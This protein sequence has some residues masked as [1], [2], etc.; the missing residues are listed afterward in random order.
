MR[1]YLLL[2]MGIYLRIIPRMRRKPGTLL[3]IEIAIC[4]SAAELRAAGIEEFYGYQL[5]KH[6]GTRGNTRLLTA[7]GTLYRALD[8]LS[9][10]GLVTSRWESPDIPARENRPG[11]RLYML[12]GAAD[13]VVEAAAR[14]RRQRVSSRVRPKLARA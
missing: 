7:Y 3:P 4:E 11:R 12:T 6:V 9:G 8:R 10:M 1:R 5:A 14:S 13:A 2:S